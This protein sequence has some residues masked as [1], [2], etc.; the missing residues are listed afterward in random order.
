[1]NTMLKQKAQAGNIP[2]LNM[3]VAIDIKKGGKGDCK[4]VRN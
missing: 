1:M 4:S 3:I 2:Q